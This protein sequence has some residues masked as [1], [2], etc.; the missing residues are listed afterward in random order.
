M[1]PVSN[2]AQDRSVTRMMDIQNGA[3]GD[4]GLYAANSA[5]EDS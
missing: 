1:I 5:E 4:H 2:A 3:N